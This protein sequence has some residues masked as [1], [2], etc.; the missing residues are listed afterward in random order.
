MTETYTADGVWLV[1]N[2]ER[3]LYVEGASAEAMAALVVA[4][5]GQADAPKQ[6]LTLNPGPT[7]LHKIREAE[8]ALAD[9]ATKATRIAL[10]KNT[11]DWACELPEAAG[12][13]R[14]EVHTLLHAASKSY[15]RWFDLETFAE[16][17]R[18]L[19]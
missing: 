14:A 3:V 6:A 15:R 1:R 16:A 19:M 11:L 9:T 8:A 13:T 12:K 2:G 5:Q 7:P 18:K 10:L 4:Y 17:Q